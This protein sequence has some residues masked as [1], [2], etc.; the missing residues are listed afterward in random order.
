M[1]T[2]FKD[3]ADQA[4]IGKLS[5]AMDVHSNGGQSSPSEM[6]AAYNSTIG[7]TPNDNLETNYQIVE[8]IMLDHEINGGV[9]NNTEL[10]S[11]R[12]IAQLCPF[13]DG[14]AVF[15]ARGLLAPI[16]S[17]EYIS[18]CEGETSTRMAAPSVDTT[19][20]F[21]FNLFP[22][23]SSGS[24]TLNYQLN[25][26]ETGALEIYSIAGS[27]VTSIPLYSGQ[28]LRTTLL[29]DLGAGTYLYKVSVNGEMKLAD[30]LVIIK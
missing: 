27:L 29:P 1:L 10:N 14:D 11:L 28:Q 22:N 20:V 13:T 26:N 6:E 30:R 15:I 24:I 21:T 2:A 4:N 19:N 3:S 18:S 9:F 12:T 23:P 5:A 16:D 17:V 8:T 7:I 25:E